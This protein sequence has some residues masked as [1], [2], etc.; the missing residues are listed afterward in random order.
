MCKLW[1][2]YS[3]VYE[4]GIIIV[5]YIIGMGLELNKVMYERVYFMVGK[6]LN[7]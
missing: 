7:M 1:I 5:F 3:F 2:F 4:I 6:I